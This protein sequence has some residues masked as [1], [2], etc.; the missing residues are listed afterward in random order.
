MRRGWHTAPPCLTLCFGRG[1]DLKCIGV[2]DGEQ[3][4]AMQSGDRMGC[5]PASLWGRFGEQALT[6]SAWESAT[7][8]RDETDAPAAVGCC[9]VVGLET[10]VKL[11]CG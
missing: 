11:L 8:G 3:D 1:R 2:T 4:G 7:W 9:L 5:T 6:H 10:A